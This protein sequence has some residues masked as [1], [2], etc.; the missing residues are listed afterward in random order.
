MKDEPELPVDFDDYD[1]RGVREGRRSG[2]SRTYPANIQNLPK[3]MDPSTRTFY[4]AGVKFRQDWRKIH[5]HLLNTDF[6]TARESLE[7]KLVGEPSNAFDKYAVK[8]LMNNEHIGYIPK[9]I[10]IDV[11]ALRDAGLKP[12]AKL[13]EFNPDAE[14]YEMFKVEVSFTK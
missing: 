7:V 1:E 13:V 3:A 9:P 5:K 14:T 12:V 2:F 8:V 10:N 11:W 4:V 6:P